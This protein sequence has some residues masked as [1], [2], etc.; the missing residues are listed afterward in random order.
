MVL[1]PVVITIQASFYRRKQNGL[2]QWTGGPISWPKSI[3]LSYT[4]LTWFFLPILFLVH[5]ETPSNFK[6]IILFHLL[7]WWTRG[8][9]EM[10]M[11]YK[12]LNWSPR[13]GIGHDLFHILGCLLFVNI[14]KQDFLTL[15]FGS[16]GFIVAIYILLLFISTTAEIGF[17]CLFLKMRTIQ[18]S[19][20]NVYFASDDP[21]W[22]FVNRITLLVV[23][24]VFIHLLYQSVYVLKYL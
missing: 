2:N 8:I 24:I 13:Y 16:Q 17:A 22:V 11:I 21:K 20:E 4:I 14:F 7:S 18:E 15:I 19:K 23:I 6:I 12:W 10:V 1:W 9:L 3:W 5:P